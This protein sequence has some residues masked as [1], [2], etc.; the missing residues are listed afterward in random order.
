LVE[1]KK[2][3]KKKPAIQRKPAKRVINKKTKKKGFTLIE[4][5][6]VIIIL[7]VLMIIAIPSVTS[8]ISDSRKNAYIDTAKEL[9]SGARTI[10]NQGNL[11]TFD[12]ATT[13]YIPT[14]C[15]TTENGGQS[16]Y[17]EFDEAYIGVIYTGEGYKYYWIS[18]DT[19]GQGIRNLTA[20]DKLTK[21]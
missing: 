20:A 11:E 15:I 21:D 18:K 19:A 8:Y 2:S 7:G 16:P 14:K 9:I 12:V 10:V 17:G 5:L 13:Y 6:A 4:L 1:Q 3:V